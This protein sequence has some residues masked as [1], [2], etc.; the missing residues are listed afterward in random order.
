MPCASLPPSLLLQA[1]GVEAAAR[2]PD[3]STAILEAP[4]QV[5]A[6]QSG[7]GVPLAGSIDIV[8]VVVVTLAG[9]GEGGAHCRALSCA[10]GPLAAGHLRKHCCFFRF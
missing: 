3:H 10:A 6:L 8:I 4:L 5:G 7:D 9:G 2:V 1:L